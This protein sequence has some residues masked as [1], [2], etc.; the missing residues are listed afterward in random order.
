MN[1]IRK[2]A[3]AAVALASAGTTVGLVAASSASATTPTPTPVK[4]TL[5][6]TAVTTRTQHI[7]PIVSIISANDY[8]T[9]T[10][11][12]GFI[13][14]GRTV[15]VCVSVPHVTPPTPTTVLAVCTWRL[16]TVPGT[17]PPTSIAGT[18]I[19]TTNGQVGRTTSGTGKDA[20]A[21]SLPLSFKSVNIA[22]NVAAD[23]YA[24][25][26]PS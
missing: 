10:A 12:P 26:T 23:T 19:E 21:T 7:G 18:S 15:E 16:T 8:A 14:V 17:H 4:H 2:A 25:T 6:V 1:L 22:P 9:E 11:S 24:F 3:I 20:G 13:L 5:T